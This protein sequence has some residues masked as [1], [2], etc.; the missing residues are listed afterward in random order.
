M[1][2][3]GNLQT[4][5]YLVTLQIILIILIGMYSSYLV[6]VNCPS[7]ETFK[8]QYNVSSQADA[9]SSIWYTIN[10]ITSGCTGIPWWIYII[11]FLPIL[12]AI[13]IYILP[14][15]LAGGG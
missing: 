5:Y 2:G 4:F 7:F 6:G 1:K 3:A 13:L 14:N 15:W 11:I 12:I 9:L 8:M 10:I